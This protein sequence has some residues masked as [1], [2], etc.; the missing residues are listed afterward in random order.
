MCYTLDY[1]PVL[2]YSFCCSDHPSFGPWGLFHLAP[3]SLLPSS[4]CLLSTFLLSTT[5]RCSRF[6][7]AIPPRSP[8]S[9]YWRVASGTKTGRWCTLDEFHAQ[10]S[11]PVWHPWHTLYF[12]VVG[13]FFFN[14]PQD[15]T[16]EAIYPS[17]DNMV[18]RDSCPVFE[19][20]FCHLRCLSVLV[21]KE[22]SNS[23][24]EMARRRYIELVYGQY[25]E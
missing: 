12:V 22:D 21:W 20:Q 4:C 8:G 25:I 24:S 16:V 2:G 19:S 14:K 3:V 23:T 17:G 1:N 6:I 5:A 13:Y 11:W 15:W 18:S 9:F 10:T 7:S